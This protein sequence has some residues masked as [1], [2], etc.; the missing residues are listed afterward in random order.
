L[1]TPFGFK[2]VLSTGQTEG[3]KIGLKLKSLSPTE[4]RDIFMSFVQI[5]Y[6]TKIIFVHQ[7]W[8][9]TKFVQYFKCLD[10]FILSCI[11]LYCSIQY[12]HFTNQTHS[13]FLLR[14]RNNNIL[15]LKITQTRT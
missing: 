13:L 2:T 5:V 11:V 8:Y 7:T 15:K 6:N 12:L 9:N 14:T 1:C 3:Q 10:S 4:P